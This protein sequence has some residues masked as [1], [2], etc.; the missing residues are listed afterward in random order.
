MTV[1]T[2]WVRLYESFIMKHEIGWNSP[3]LQS[4][5]HWFNGAISPSKRKLKPVISTGADSKFVVKT[6]LELLRGKKKKKVVWTIIYIN[7]YICVCVFVF[8]Y[9]C[10]PKEEFPPLFYDLKDYFFVFSRSYHRRGKNSSFKRMI[11]KLFGQKQLGKRKL[12]CP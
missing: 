5:R 7:V 2:W 10:F 3:E 1:E 12:K 4:C 6:G 8:K 11:W 9:S